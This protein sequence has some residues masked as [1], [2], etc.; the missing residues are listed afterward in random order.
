MADSRC[1]ELLR[2]S[3]AT[4]EEFR[5]W[6][7]LCQDIARNFYPM[8]ADFTQTLDLGDFAGDL[9]DGFPVNA[10]ETLGNAID[11]ML[12]QENGAQG[13]FHVGSGDL[14]L[15]ARPANLVAFNVA[16]NK[17]RSIL[18]NPA[19]GWQDA[20]KELDMD[21]V[22]FGTACGSV[23]E[24]RDR[25]HVSVRAWHPRDCA[26]RFDE[27]GALDTFYR[28]IELTARD[29]KRRFDSGRWSGTMAPAIRDAALRDPGKRFRVRHI[30]MRS[31]EIYGSSR[32]DMR[33]IRHPF[34]SIY[35]DV[36]NRTYLNEA[37][38]PVFNYFVAR[39]RTLS[40][41][42]QG[43]SPMALN[44]LPDA[45]MLQDIA[46]T[47]LEQGQKAN[48]PPTIGAGNVFTRDMNFFAGG[49][50]EVDLEEGQ[51][52]GDVFTTIETGNFNA[53]LEIKADVRNLLAEAWLLNKLML[54]TLRD[55]RELEVQVRTDE[56]R[57]AA[58]P[59]FKPI[60]TNYHNQVLGVVYKVAANMRIINPA[61]FAAEL[62]D[63]P[64][65]FTFD[66]P[67]N[68]AE[69]TEIVRAYYE[70][71]NIVGAGAKVDATVANIFDLRKATEDALSRGTRAE[72]LIPE[73]QREEAANQAD[74]VS[75][76][77]QGAQIAREAAGVTAD[78]SAASMA[79]QQAGLA[80]A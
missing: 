21:W 12:R 56:F 59:F 66:S 1:E 25:D 79:A 2:L 72:W 7:Q 49:H 75:G 50:T 80:P 52:L 19:S 76:L 8:R 63:R 39:S 67:L 38:A 78:V 26:W 29:I 30:L 47:V 18:K 10:R 73:D 23:E 69:G 27:D 58:L 16:T 20:S 62:G 17:M 31:D 41:K 45:R 11:A 3:S 68:E 40:G 5:P 64:V 32:A 15:D 57:R 35:I 61:M 37:G 48:D 53:G 6:R 54:P 4:F 44:S 43:F 28:D 14:E 36:D 22:A 34:I 13:W 42:P 74:V 51:K 55:M 24:S 60:D 9:M 65:A 77:T 71:L 70:A 33:R 46:L